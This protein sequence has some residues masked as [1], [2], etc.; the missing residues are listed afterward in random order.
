MAVVTGFYHT[1]GIDAVLEHSPAEY[2]RRPVVANE[3]LLVAVVGPPSVPER[4]PQLVH[5]LSTA[6]IEHEAVDDAD[7]GCGQGA[8]R[9]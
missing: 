8:L 5:G 6:S 3:L 9:R 1:C 2:V 4:A 7:T